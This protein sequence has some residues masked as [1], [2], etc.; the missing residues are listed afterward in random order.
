ME[1]KKLNE[2]NDEALDTVTGG[3]TAEAKFNEQTGKWDVIYQGACVASYDTQVE[4]YH[5]F[6][7]KSTQTPPPGF[8]EIPDTPRVYIPPK[9]GY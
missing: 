1:E 2:L 5:H 8:I 9:T 3:G 4:A 7:G 6:I